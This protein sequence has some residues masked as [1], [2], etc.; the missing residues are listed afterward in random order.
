M[1]KFV[2]ALMAVLFCAGVALAQNAAETKTAANQVKSASPEAKPA[3]NQGGA[4]PSAEAAGVKVEKIVAAAGVTDKEPS[5][6]NTAFGAGTTEV[7]CWMKVT[8][9]TDTVI[10]HIWYSDGTK[11]AAIPLQIKHNPMRTWSSKIV[12]GGKWKVEAVDSTGAV[13]GTVEFTVAK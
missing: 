10:T 7:Y 5:G 8:G 2:P 12:W 4:A 6:E 13:I 3:A 9:T 11:V 1:K